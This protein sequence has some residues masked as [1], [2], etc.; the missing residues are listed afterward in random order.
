MNP[1]FLDKQHTEALIRAKQDRLSSTQQA[2]VDSG[3]TSELV[4]KIKDAPVTSVNRMTGD[5]VLNATDIELGPGGTGNVFDALSSK[6]DKTLESST[7]ITAKDRLVFSDKSGTNTLVW[8]GRQNGFL[9]LTG[10]T[11]GIELYD[12][13]YINV[14]PSTSNGNGGFAAPS[15]ANYR[16]GDWDDGL[17]LDGLLS[18]MSVSGTK[19]YY[20]KGT[21]ARGLIKS[22][23]TTNVTDVPYAPVKQVGI[24][25]SND[26]A[27]QTS[28][29][30]SNIYLKI[31]PL[32]ADGT[33]DSVHAVRSTNANKIVANST[34]Y[35]YDFASFS[36]PVGCGFVAKLV[37]ANGAEVVSKLSLYKNEPAKYYKYK[38]NNGSEITSGYFPTMRF[39]FANDIDGKVS[40]TGDTISGNIVANIDCGFEVNGTTGDSVE[41]AHHTP[42]FGFYRK[43]GTYLTLPTVTTGET[44]AVKSEIPT[45]MDIATSVS[46]GDLIDEIVSGRGK[47][48]LKDTVDS[49][50]ASVAQA[51]SEGVLPDG[52]KKRLTSDDVVFHE[53]SVVFE[54]SGKPADAAGVV[55]CFSKDIYTET[56]PVYYLKGDSNKRF[57]KVNSIL[58]RYYDGDRMYD[59]EPG[60]SMLNVFDA[61]TGDW[62]AGI[63]MGTAEEPTEGNRTVTYS[64]VAA[65]D[66]S[67]WD[68]SQV[69]LLGKY[70][71]AAYVKTEYHR[72]T[73]PKAEDITDNCRRTLGYPIKV[74]F[75]GSSPYP[76]VRLEDRTVNVINVN[77]GC[78]NMYIYLPPRQEGRARDFIVRLTI[79]CDTIPEFHLYQSSSTEPPME[80]ESED[81]N[82]SSFS[83]G[84]NIL[85][86]TE[87]MQ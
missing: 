63:I 43:D 47:D 21:V 11:N 8:D 49:I 70:E 82:W 75:D 5:V 26:V 44:I 27:S 31:V 28:V 3:I 10:P 20:T 67:Y 12:G 79:K 68:G 34:E 51:I 83:G 45:D 24:V 64:Y 71:D 69:A 65:S 40:K 76:S 48:T 1:Q 32:K 41:F 30:K 35:L 53:S 25:S 84:V 19:Q 80:F 42:G 86:F 85:S 7:T 9:A 61:T 15:L 50:N 29:Y 46:A 77:E 18:N 33:E 72:D 66:E 13:A 59:F 52:W 57:E 62:L 74:L 54:K 6:L 73:A 78:L 22:W 55:S 4:A 39:V 58:Y 60:T 23:T 81:S 56:G 16:I 14:D 17:G 37:D 87:T 36:I 38:D 2:A